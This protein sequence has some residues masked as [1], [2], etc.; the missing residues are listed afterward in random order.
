MGDYTNKRELGGGPLSPALHP[1]LYEAQ[2]WSFL[3]VEDIIEGK[4]SLIFYDYKHCGRSGGEQLSI[5]YLV[6]V[7]KSTIES[8]L[9][10]RM[11]SILELW[12]CREYKGFGR[13]TLSIHI[14]CYKR[15]LVLPVNF[16]WC[17]IFKAKCKLGVEYKVFNP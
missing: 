10:L 7:T 5:V 13:A 4:N 8:I 3:C 11:Q 12:M 1:F 16:T 9:E 6:S 15:D 2:E 14:T 17:S